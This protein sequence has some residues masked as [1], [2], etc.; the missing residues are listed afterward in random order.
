MTAV[1][2]AQ[3][4]IRDRANAEPSCVAQNGFCPDWIRDHI[5]DYMSPLLRHLELTVVSVLAGFAIAFA[6][7]LLAHRHRWL[8]GPITGI[9]GVMYTIPSL[10]LFAI[11]LPITGF[12]FVTGVIALTSYNL[13]V[14]FRNIMV[15]LDNVP[16]AAKD[17]A[18]G[19]GM[20]DRQRLWR[21][22]LPLALPE[23]VAGVRVATTT[24]VGLAALAFI[25][26]AGGLGQQ[27]I[28]D[29]VFKS[30]IVTASVLCIL[31]AAALDLAILGAQRAALPWRRATG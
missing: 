29:I 14:I 8:N 26:G 13:L 18:T 20:T 23:L 16:E 24:T 31:L 19:M 3:V 28:T 2:L 7:A 9:T 5:G 21:V 15:G 1:T 25:A 10:A 22:E 4:Q 11:L 12:G 17:A 30:N 27:I 6:L